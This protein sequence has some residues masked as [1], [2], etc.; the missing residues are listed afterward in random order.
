MIEQKDFMEERAINLIYAGA[1]TGKS[2]F[3]QSLIK[4]LLP[5]RKDK[6]FIYLDND[7]SAMTAKRRK[8]DLISKEDNFFYIGKRAI[9]DSGGGKNF[10]NNVL[11]NISA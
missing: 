3:I 5:L 4:Y 8:L 2:Y 9:I 10:V 11:L 7:N 1:K 6:K